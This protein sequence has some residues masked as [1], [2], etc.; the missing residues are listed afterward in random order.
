MELAPGETRHVSVTLGQRAFSY[1]DVA[2]HAWTA[3]VGDY[4]IYVALSAEQIELTGAITR[5][6]Q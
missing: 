6:G 1:Y 5:S 4:K 3:D 2:T